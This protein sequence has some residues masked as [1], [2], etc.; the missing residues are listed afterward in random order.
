MTHEVRRWAALAAAGI[1]TGLLPVISLGSPAAAAEGCEHEYNPVPPL[2]INSGYTCD[3]VTQPETRVTASITPNAAGWINTNDVT[4][5][6]GVVAA[7]DPDESSMT[8]RCSLTGPSQAF[9]EKDCTSP[10]TLTDLADGIEAYTFRVHA[11]DDGGLLEIHGDNEVDESDRDI[12]DIQT[13]DEVM[14]ND[15]DQT[16][17]TVSWKIDTTTPRGLIVGGPYDQYSPDFPVL[18]GH[19]TSYTLGSTEKAAIPTCAVNGVRV[20]CQLG[21]TTVRGLTAGTKTFSMVVRDAAGNTDTVR[22]KRLTVPYNIIGTATELQKWKR[23]AAA[24]MYDGDYYQTS[25]KGAT[26]SRKV[27]F[28]ELRIM[29]ATGPTLGKIRL[30]LGSHYFPEINTY[31][32]KAGRRMV[33]L[34]DPAS[35][36]MS[37]LL[38]II[39]VTT[40][41][42][43][44]DGLMYR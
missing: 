24:G 12:L 9:A 22:T 36:R 10:I 39:N 27:S 1:I 34:R 38:Q 25:L 2:N 33:V 29:V 17:A 5:T 18:W 3:D 43:R 42:I 16:P 13:P 35:T 37:G 19:S 31:A 6:F 11:I 7:G 26:L 32:A 44:V 8:L 23:V 40:K 30:K 21:V 15:F 14:K 4:L 41:P 20:G 28:I